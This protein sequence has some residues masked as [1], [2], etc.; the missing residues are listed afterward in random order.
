MTLR[1]CRRHSRWFNGTEKS[2]KGNQIET[3]CIT[4]PATIILIRIDVVTYSISFS[5]KSNN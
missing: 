5:A 4:T 1:L 2:I 3:D